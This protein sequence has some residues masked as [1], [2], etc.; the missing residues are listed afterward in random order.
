MSS[1]ICPVLNFLVESLS[2]YDLT[3]DI[4]YRIIK[5]VAQ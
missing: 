4:L 3:G 1:Q 5:R 2:D